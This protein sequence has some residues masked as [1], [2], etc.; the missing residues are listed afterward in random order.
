MSDHKCTRATLK[1]KTHGPDK[2]VIGYTCSSCGAVWQSVLHE[3]AAFWYFFA[4]QLTE[5]AKKA[6]SGSDPATNLENVS[7]LPF[8][9]ANSAILMS[10]LSKD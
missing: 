1:E 3:D 5:E 8:L 10:K 7:G 6:V 9:D 4:A 2:R